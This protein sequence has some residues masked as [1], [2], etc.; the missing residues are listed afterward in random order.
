MS[1]PVCYRC[2]DVRQDDV[3]VKTEDEAVDFFLTTAIALATK[4]GEREMPELSALGKTKASNTHVEAVEFN[5]TDLAMTIGFDCYDRGHFVGTPSAVEKAT[6]R[7]EKIYNEYIIARDKAKDPTLKVYEEYKPK[8]DGAKEDYKKLY[9]EYE[10]KCEE[11]KE[12]KRKANDEREDCKKIAKV[13][14]N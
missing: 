3:Y 13:N 5:T 8:L 4:N 11:A 1:E 10:G 6:E 9:A 12:T 14:L 2:L 7:Y